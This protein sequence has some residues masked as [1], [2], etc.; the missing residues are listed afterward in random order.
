M[1]SSLCDGDVLKFN[2][3]VLYKTPSLKNKLYLII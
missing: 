2:T 3:K 1:H